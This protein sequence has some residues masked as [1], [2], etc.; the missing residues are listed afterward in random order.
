MFIKPNNNKEGTSPHKNTTAHGTGHLWMEDVLKEAPY[1]VLRNGQWQLRSSCHRFQGCSH[2]MQ[3][4]QKP[5]SFYHLCGFSWQM[6]K[7][8]GGFQRLM[9]LGTFRISCRVCEANVEI[10]LEPK[11]IESTKTCFET[12][13]KISLLRRLCNLNLKHPWISKKNYPI[14]WFYVITAMSHDL[15]MKSFT[16]SSRP[17]EGHLYVP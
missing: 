12:A 17:V 11:V 9:I 1:V 15:V 16:K 13:R 10:S 8:S 6:L 7:A 5:T 3:W 14:F 2:Q 4:Q